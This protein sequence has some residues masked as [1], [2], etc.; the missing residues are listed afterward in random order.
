VVKIAR[1]C[2]VGQR[3]VTR[4]SPLALLHTAAAG[5]AFG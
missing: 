4:H 1:R 5:Y 2:R 3:S